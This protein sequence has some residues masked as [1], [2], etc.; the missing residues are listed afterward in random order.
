[1]WGLLPDN[2]V[3]L[4][5]W[6]QRY[7]V[8]AGNPFALLAAMGEDCPGAVQLAPPGFDLAERGGVQWIT[9]RG[10]D[11]RIRALIEDPGAGRLVGDTGQFSLAR[12]AGSVAQAFIKRVG[13]KNQ[14]SG[15]VLR[16][17]SRISERGLAQWRTCRCAA[18]RGKSWGGGNG[19][20]DHVN[21]L[22]NPLPS[23]T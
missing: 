12:P 18:P 1:M 5:R 16:S 23:D 8:S 15:N 7:Q 19:S 13:I 4:D 9:P 2:A 11:E 10:L 14:S 3:T 17:H 6:A 20:P 21:Q 22:R